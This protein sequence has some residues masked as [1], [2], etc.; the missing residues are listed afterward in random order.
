VIL[1]TFGIFTQLNTVVVNKGAEMGLEMEEKAAP[2][3]E[4]VEDNADEAPEN[5]KRQ[6]RDK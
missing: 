1:A 6:S 3:E 2:E 4:K 5:K